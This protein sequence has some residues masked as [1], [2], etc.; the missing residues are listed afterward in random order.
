V[1]GQNVSDDRTTTNH[2]DSMM[3]PFADFWA[4]CQKQADDTTREY[5]KGLD[6]STDVKEWQRRWFNA[7]SK[8]MDS[9]MRSPAFLHAMKHNTEFAIKAKR[10]SQDI[11]A[12]IARN[13]NL[14]TATDIS[15][16]F[17]RLHSVEEVILARLGR[18]EE[19]LGTIEKHVGICQPSQ[20]YH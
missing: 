12:E 17:E 1:E 2:F 8:S 11:T 15:G 19:R 16:L 6:G 4:S 9:Y 18:I 10:Q 14:P 7:V 5:L 20:A 13:V 3:Q